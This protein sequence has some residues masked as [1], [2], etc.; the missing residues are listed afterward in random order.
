[1]VSQ[2]FCVAVEIIL[3]TGAAATISQDTQ[4]A[5]YRC[6]Y[7]LASDAG[8]FFFVEKI[9]IFAKFA[10]WLYDPVLFV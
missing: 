7:R 5:N 6:R 8:A 2:F 3:G 1:M 4:W 9:S 10:K